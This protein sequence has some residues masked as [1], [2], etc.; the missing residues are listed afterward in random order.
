M[1]K[2]SA[3]LLSLNASG[4]F[5]D[6]LVATRWKGQAVLRKYSIPANPN[7]TDQQTQRA[8][9]TAAVSRWRTDFINSTMR[10]AWQTLATKLSEAMSGFNKFAQQVVKSYA[11][12]ISFVD[13][14]TGVLDH[15]LTF[16]LKNTDDGATGDEAGNFEL[17]I[18]DGLNNIQYFGT[19]AI[20]AGVLTYDVHATWPAGTDAFF[21]V[22]KDG[23]YR[24]G[25]FNETLT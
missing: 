11:A 1:S 13:E 8:K 14:N 9:V 10:V 18:G 15:A 7:T 17:W 24:S 6:T 20:A 25:L 2:V 23:Y 5:A 22:Q 12:N 4:K 21:Y 3:P 19:A 16:H